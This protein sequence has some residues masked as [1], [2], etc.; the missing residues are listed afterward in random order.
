ML[1]L[2]ISCNSKS[3]V[4]SK[5]FNDTISARAAYRMIRHY[6]DTSVNHDLSHLISYIRIDKQYLNN[7][8]Q[9]E[10]DISFWTAADTNTNQLKVIIELRGIPANGGKPQFYSA[11]FVI[12]PPPYAPPC[13]TSKNGNPDEFESF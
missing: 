4:S 1:I 9:D 13:D 10:G 11:P 5:Y 8:T 2:I 3:S 12:C 7:L 6:K